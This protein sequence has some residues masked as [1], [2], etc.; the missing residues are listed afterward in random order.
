MRATHLVAALALALTT[1]GGLGCGDDGGGGAAAKSD[2]AAQKAAAAKKAQAKKDKVKPKKLE[3]ISYIQTLEKVVP[4]AEAG[5]IRR[6]LKDRDFQSDLTGTEN[7]NPFQ[8]FTL[9]Q[10]GTDQAPTL[11][12][13]PG[14]AAQPTDLCARSKLIASNYALKDL[15]LIGVVRRGAQYFALF[16]DSHGVG[17]VIE[18]GKCL[19]RE[20]AL[21]TAIGDGLV[22]IQRL[23][24]AI[25]G[26]PEPVPVT[27]TIP[28][29]QTEIT[30]D[31]FD[32][33]EAAPPED[34]GAGTEPAPPPTG[35]PASPTPDPTTTP[36]P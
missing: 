17:H 16:R 3:V 2:P 9:P 27:E 23:P 22:T 29:Y 36:S 12:V 14:P 11:P 6:R 35:D 26:G 19:G 15:A 30:A 33:E 7:R 5:T 28:L 4:E 20:K 21:V 1:L 31:D 34:P 32:S 10:V 18:R 25:V 8:S 24:E 13:G